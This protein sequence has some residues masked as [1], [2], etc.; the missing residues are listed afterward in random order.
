MHFNKVMFPNKTRN[1]FLNKTRNL[2]LLSRWTVS[3]RQGPVLGPIYI[4]IWHNLWITITMRP[5]HSKLVVLCSPASGPNYFHSVTSLVLAFLDLSSRPLRT[6]WKYFTRSS[7]QLRSSLSLSSAHAG[8]V[9]QWDC[10]SL[11]RRQLPQRR[12][13]SRSSSPRP[14]VRYFDR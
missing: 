1:L 8:Q 5:R 6:R 3:A 2:S 11:A 10:E 12:P 14:M 4:Y 9:R 13:G 7:I